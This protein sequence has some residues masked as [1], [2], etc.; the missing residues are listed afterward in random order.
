[1]AN[2]AE[3]LTQQLLEQRR[4]ER[5]REQE[6]TR[7]R[8]RQQQGWRDDFDPFQIMNWRGVAG[9]DRGYLP[10]M[11]MRKG[12]DGFW[13]ACRGCGQ[14]FE[15]KGMAYCQSCL[16]LPAE[17]R[18]DMKPSARAC[19]APGCSNVLAASAR[20]DARYCS[21]ACKKRALRERLKGDKN[22]DQRLDSMVDEMSPSTLEKDE[23][24]QGPKIE[25][26]FPGLSRD[27]LA[28]VRREMSRNYPDA[29]ADQI[30]TA[31]A[32]ILTPGSTI[33][34]DI[35]DVVRAAF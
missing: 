3:R 18:R 5:E 29:T 17:E 8:A 1:M 24:N 6:R 16:V 27:Q 14:K 15:S 20:V 2:E 33:G 28:A 12:K 25:P 7:E 9:G 21:T 31:T 32:A 30:D 35:E 19:E 13:I 26:R 34:R 4:Q 23:Q 10:K 22:E 11:S